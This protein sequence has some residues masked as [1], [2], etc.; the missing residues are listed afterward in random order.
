MRR[1]LAPTTSAWSQVGA[2]VLYPGV[3]AEQ[4]AQAAGGRS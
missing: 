1:R 3:P 4:D 2:T